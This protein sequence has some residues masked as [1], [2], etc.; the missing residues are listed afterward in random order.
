MQV[1]SKSRDH[2]DFL[3][4]EP[5]LLEEKE[6]QEED[7]KLFQNISGQSFPLSSATVPQ[8]LGCLLLPPGM[9]TGP[10][11]LPFFPFFLPSFL[12]LLHECPGKPLV[13]RPI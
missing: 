9:V 12:P 10:S 1:L 5:A 11:F 8:G 6:N 3:E 13:E 4:V 7:G 2:P